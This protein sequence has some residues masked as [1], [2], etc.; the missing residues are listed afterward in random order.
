MEDEDDM[1]LFYADE[2][3]GQMSDI[4]KIFSEDSVS[5]FDGFTTDDIEFWIDVLLYI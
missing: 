3:E 1:D 4:L 5:S 2:N